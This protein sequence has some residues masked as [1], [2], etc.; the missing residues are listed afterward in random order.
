MSLSRPHTK[1]TARESECPGKNS[2]AQVCSFKKRCRQCGSTM[3]EAA[4]VIPIFLLFFIGMLETASMLETRRSLSST[5]D[6]AVREAASQTGFMDGTSYSNLHRQVS[7]NCSGQGGSDGNTT[8]VN[9]GDCQAHWN[10]QQRLKTLIDLYRGQKQLPFVDRERKALNPS[11]YTIKT[12]VERTDTGRRL[13]IELHG[14]YR[15]LTSQALAVNFTVT[16]YGPII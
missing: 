15:P 2:C 3:I 16:A 10:I 5:V 6:Q 11:S 1:N 13:V 8:P 12:T 14:P 4:I 7:A 9:P